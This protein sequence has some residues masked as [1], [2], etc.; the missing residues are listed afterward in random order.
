ML[1]AIKP[2]LQRVQIT[3]FRRRREQRKSVRSVAREKD[4]PKSPIFLHCSFRKIKPPLQ[5]GANYVLPSQTGAKGECPERSEGEGFSKIPH[6]SFH[7]KS[8][9][10]Y[11]R[12]QITPFPSGTRKKMAQICSLRSQIKDSFIYIFIS[13]T[14]RRWI[15]P[16]P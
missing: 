16:R 3:S 14:H 12:V 1:Q 5:K 15:S 4:F 13:T 8:S 2:P 6:F 11:K 7:S 9:P 10:L